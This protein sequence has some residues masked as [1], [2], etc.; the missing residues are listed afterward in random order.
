MYL[1]VL[2]ML[3]LII[4]SSF[5]YIWQS[6][7]KVQRMNVILEDI[8]AGNL[9]RKL[10]AKNHSEL[11][12]T[13]FIINEIVAKQK[14]ELV[15]LRQS[16]K[17]Y[18]QLV[19]S[20]SHDLRTPLASLMGYLSATQDGIVIG[21]DREEYLKLSYEKAITLKD[22]ID[23]LFEWLKLESGERIFHF[24]RIDI[25]ELSR[26]IM[27]EWIPQLEQK[28]IEY[29]IEIPE[30]EIYLILDESSYRRILY[31]LLQNLLIHSQADKMKL[32]IHELEEKICIILKDNGV[33]ISQKD[34]SHIFERLYKCDSAR[35]GKGSGLGLA[36]VNELIKANNGRIHAESEG[37]GSAFIVELPR[38]K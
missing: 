17:K 4:V 12:K 14:R 16:E 31:N 28:Q 24:E 1:G 9:D 19:T 6:R 30:Q 25:C 27:S 2:V 11:A 18:K 22:Y 38:S 7:K 5:F 15:E 10:I 26:E 33:G 35:N 34:L 36:I 8:L 37:E 32:E 23:T 3:I 20:L 13:Y 21:E 29:N